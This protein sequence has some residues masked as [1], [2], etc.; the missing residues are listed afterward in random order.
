MDHHDPPSRRG[1]NNSSSTNSIETTAH[2]SNIMPPYRRRRSTKSTFTAHAA[3]FD[4]HY[5]DPVES[6]AGDDALIMPPPAAMLFPPPAPCS[7]FPSGRHQVVSSRGST[8]RRPHSSSLPRRHEP[9]YDHSLAATGSSRISKRSNSMG[10]DPPPNAKEEKDTPHQLLGKTWD[11][12][13]RTADNNGDC[14]HSPGVDGSGTGTTTEGLTDDQSED[15]FGED[16]DNCEEHYRQLPPPKLQCS[17]DKPVVAQ[18]QIVLRGRN[19][20]PEEYSEE[21]T[22]A[23]VR[24]PNH[25]SH[26]KAASSNAQKNPQP[27]TTTLVD[28]SQ[29]YNGYQ[30]CFITIKEE[31]R[32][33]VLYTFLKRS[34]DEKI[35]I[36]FSTTKSTQYYG[37]LLTR[38]KLDV[39]VMHNGQSRETFLDTFFQFS[40]KKGGGILCIP[41]FQGNEVTIPPSTSWIVQFEPCADPSE[42][43]FRVGRISS[44][45]DGQHSKSKACRPPNSGS[46]SNGRARALLFLTPDQFGFLKYYKAAKVKYYE[47][48]IPKIANVQKELMRLVRKDDKLRKI[49]VEAYHAYLMAY[50]SQEYRDI[51]NVHDLDRRRVALRFGFEKPPSRENENVVDDDDEVVVVGATQQQQESRSCRKSREEQARWKPEK[52]EATSWK[53]KPAKNETRGGWMTGEKSWRYANVHADKMKVQRPK[54]GKTNPDDFKPKTIKFR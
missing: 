41:D 42:Y 47:Y 11:R 10:S 2:P 28:A 21:T 33:L 3:Y 50:A 8:P 24:H 32:F 23:V 35:I 25:R 31:H 40:R 51:Y 15:D 17:P 5:P 49:G 1:N 45:R 7:P 9:L 12:H 16:E 36:F 53:T 14:Y 37:R 13:H 34:L 26:E 30:H 19:L 38:L 18:Q 44:E 4:E 48:E 27:T 46:T 29:K 54:D 43:I 20:E 22:N 39:Q 52:H 6:V